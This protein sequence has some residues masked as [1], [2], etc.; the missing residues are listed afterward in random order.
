MHSLTAEFTFFV[1]G[2]IR[3]CAVTVVGCSVCLNTPIQT[4]Q[5]AKIQVCNKK[6]DTVEEALL[7]ELVTVSDS[8]CSLMLIGNVNLK[9]SAFRPAPLISCNTVVTKEFRIRLSSFGMVDQM[10]VFQLFVSKRWR[11]S[12]MRCV[13]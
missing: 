11:Q 8:Q 6:T 5:T 1:L 4:A 12:E 7:Q 9:Y 2:V 13:H 10:G 3:Q